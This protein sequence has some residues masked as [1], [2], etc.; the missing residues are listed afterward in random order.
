MTATGVSAAEPP[1]LNKE[2]EMNSAMP[3]HLEAMAFM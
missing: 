3:K 1:G 2:R